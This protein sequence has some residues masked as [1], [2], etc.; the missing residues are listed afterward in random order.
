MERACLVVLLL[1]SSSL[2]Q[3]D[4]GAV[5][6]IK[7]H[8]NFANGVCDPTARVRLMGISGL[9]AEAR[10][11]E[12]CEVNFANLP[13]GTY[14]VEV[15]GQS[16]PAIV[17]TIA[18][19]TGNSNFEFKVKRADEAVGGASIGPLVSAATLSIPE[20]AL[21]EFRKSNELIS[22]QEY[23]KAIQTLNRAIAIYPN[24][25]AAYNNLGAVYQ[26]L[27]DR[28]KEREYFQKAVSLDDHFAA[29]YLNLGR[30]EVTDQNFSAGEDVLTKAASYNPSDATA[31]ML[32][33][34]CQ[35]QDRHF[36]DAIASSRKAHALPSEHASVHMIAAKSFE[37]KHNA[38]GAIAELE[39]F[40]K[41]EPAGERAE[42][43]RKDLAV[44]QAIP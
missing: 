18:T 21:K 34:Y 35:F 44:L 8:L 42:Q 4:T 5:R 26:R 14:Q 36:D 22:R 23:P 41:E 13:S 29:A 17:E 2:A 39:L 38:P 1:A 19:T 27:G 33:S 37:Q 25:A 7:L 20:K 11:D 28:A 3:F 32:L 43:A 30:M 16:F 24:Y 15:S 40:L 10:P 31:L 12:Q 9:A 6:H